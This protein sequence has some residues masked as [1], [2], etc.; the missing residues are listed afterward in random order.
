MTSKLGIKSP[1]SQEVYVLYRPETG[2]YKGFKLKKHAT[3]ECIKDVIK[4][5]EGNQYPFDYVL[6]SSLIEA[7]SKIGDNAKPYKDPN[8][9]SPWMY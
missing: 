7:K 2:R 8:S 6:A 1:W 4:K 3:D 5:E 9:P